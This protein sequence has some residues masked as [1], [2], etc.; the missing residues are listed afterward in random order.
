MFWSIKYI[1]NREYKMYWQ[2]E[3]IAKLWVLSI[4]LT[5]EGLNKYIKLLCEMKLREITDV[6]CKKGVL[7]NFAKFTW[8]HLCW[9]L[10]FNKLAGLRPE[11]L[12]K[13]DS[14]TGVFRWILWNFLRTPFLQNLCSGCFFIKD[15][16]LSIFCNDKSFK[17]IFSNLLV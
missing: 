1:H 12:L 2:N 6:F 5:K 10:F 8:K 11:S 16:F 13:R 14:D 9:S 3:K 15:L 17:Q 4:F 7:R